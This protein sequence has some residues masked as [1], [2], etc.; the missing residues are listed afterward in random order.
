MQK[1][2]INNCFGGFGLSLAAQNLFAR[3][4]GF[5]LFHYKQ[6]EYSH[7]HGED[8]YVRVGE[9]E[10]ETLFVHSYTTDMGEEFSGD[11]NDDSY[12]SYYDI[13]RT[14]GALIEVVEEL[15]ESA[16]G[17]CAK[18]SV[19]E[20]PDDVEWKIEEYDGNEWVAEAH[21]TWS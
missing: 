19:V 6:T 12:W 8:V 20:I 5:E 1:V 15:G 4:K 14:D 21:R 18:L 16:N 3:K 13:E 10:E 17:P 2:V 7:S 11:A 9:G